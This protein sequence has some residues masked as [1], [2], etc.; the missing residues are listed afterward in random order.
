[1]YT[2]AYL[3]GRGLLGEGPAVLDPQCRRHL[4]HAQQL[5][6]QRLG[7]RLDL[8]VRPLLLDL[9]PA[10]A[11][12]IAIAAAAIALGGGGGGGPALREVRARV[13]GAPHV[14]GGGVEAVDAAE[15]DV[16]V[17]VERGGEVPPPLR[18]EAG[19]DD[20]VLFWGGRGVCKG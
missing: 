13:A 3:L 17:C 5:G 18:E 9:V 16:R 15:V 7:V 20:A 8:P 12:A 10:L 1:M 4:L 14:L 11:V 19:G 6:Q 2:R